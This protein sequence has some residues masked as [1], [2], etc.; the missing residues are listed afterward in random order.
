MPCRGMCVLLRAVLVN[1]A[2]ALAGDPAGMAT[3]MG[4]AVEAGRLAYC[5][6][7]LPKRARA[8]ASSPTQGLVA[9]KDS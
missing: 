4:Q 3:A 6:G 1:S 9:G 2:I 7:R 5:S 8:S